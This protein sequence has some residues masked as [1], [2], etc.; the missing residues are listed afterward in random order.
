M[1]RR[2]GLAGK[3]D[4]EF[5]QADMVRSCLVWPFSASLFFTSLYIHIHECI[6]SLYVVFLGSMP[7][8][9]RLEQVAQDDV[10]RW[11]DQ[12]WRGKHAGEKGDIGDEKI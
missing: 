2:S 6:Y 7:L 8:R 3:T 12:S 5:A 4:M 11:S 1:A 10:R 9:G